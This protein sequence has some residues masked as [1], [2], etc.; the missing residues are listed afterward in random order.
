MVNVASR[1]IL[2]VFLSVLVAASIAHAQEGGTPQQ[3]AVDLSDSVS[4][5]DAAVVSNGVFTRSIADSLSINDFASSKLAIATERHVADGVDAGDA[6]I[7]GF[8][9][10]R[11]AF[12]SLSVG[13]PLVARGPS[14]VSLSEPVNI[15]DEITVSGTLLPRTAL[16]VSLQSG[17]PVAF[18]PDGDGIDDSVEIVF[19]SSS[20]GS[21]V[22]QVRDAQGNMASSITGTMITGSNSVTWDGTDSS[23]NPVSAGVYTYYIFA[24]S[25][26]GAR[27][28]PR[29]GDGTIVVQGPSTVPTTP[30]EL[31]YLAL[32][33]AVAAAAGGTI[34]FF[35]LRRRKE[36]IVYLPVAASQVIGEI[37]QK[38][39]SATVEDFIEPVE[40]GSELY[41]GV[42]IENPS[43]EDESWFV[44]VISKAKDIAR[45]DSV[46]VSYQGKLRSI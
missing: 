42:K 21:Y 19:D 4:V 46:N 25:E 3:L 34:L 17:Q 36:L 26:D 2:V 24:R 18:T 38:Y 29:G 43:E 16:T 44:E 35:F 6:I 11:F 27:D 8:H 41:K 7:K 28:P 5:S 32:I 37:K 45:V 33:T 9:A 22:F 10:F 23:D 40:G 20:G 31:N 12:D 39:P 1:G 13:D 15:A 14:V 30:S